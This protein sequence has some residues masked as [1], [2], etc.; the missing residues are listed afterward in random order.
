[1]PM[2]HV[3]DKYVLPYE[4]TGGLRD[5]LQ[6]KDSWSN[7]WKRCG[8]E[9]LNDPELG[10]FTHYSNSFKIWRMQQHNSARIAKQ[11]TGK[12]DLSKLL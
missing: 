10:R 3:I 7:W 11:S 8:K 12:Q 1:M 9:R 4:G 5:R 6:E 2:Q